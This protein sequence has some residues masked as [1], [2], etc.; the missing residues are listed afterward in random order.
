[1]R[2]PAQAD[3]ARNRLS[4]PVER[5]RR[6]PLLLQLDTGRPRVHKAQI[7][8]CE[9]D[10]HKGER[11][12]QPLAR[13]KAIAGAAKGV[14]TGLQDRTAAVAARVKAGIPS[15]AGQAQPRVLKA[16]ARLRDSPLANSPLGSAVEA[17]LEQRLQDGDSL[18]DALASL[19]AEAAAKVARRA[20]VLQALSA[21]AGL[22]RDPDKRR[23]LRIEVIQAAKT[24]RLGA[25]ETWDRVTEIVD[26]S[27]PFLAWMERRIGAPMTVSLSNQV[28]AGFVAGVQYAEGISGIR[29]GVACFTRGVSVSLGVT[30]EAS[31][32]IQIGVALG[33]PAAGWSYA[34]EVGLGGG[35]GGALGA[36]AAFNTALIQPI[37]R[38]EG[39]VARQV[40]QRV[41][42]S[43]TAPVIDYTF[44]GLSASVGS[45]GGIDLGIAWGASHSRL[46][47]GRI[48]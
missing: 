10:G 3:C 13:G 43:L 36:S 29:H 35:T 22:W 18:D 4:L 16:L 23:R 25:A 11:V 5:R 47:A 28:K 34:A 14:A 1:L 2:A 33:L 27:M 39:Q 38:D 21:A 40:A 20:N 6:R 31:F 45:G 7:V 41:G 46:L 9:F 15:V 32:G 19:R 44:S 42:R 30:D 26:T 8:R 17:W 48:H 12:I 24:G 37:E